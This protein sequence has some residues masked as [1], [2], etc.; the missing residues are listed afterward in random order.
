MVVRG[1]VAACGRQR[2][3]RR[4]VVV[5]RVLVVQEERGAFGVG[6]GLLFDVGEALVGGGA[7]GRTWWGGR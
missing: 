5:V 1:G 2:A 7:R 6:R 4:E 3:R